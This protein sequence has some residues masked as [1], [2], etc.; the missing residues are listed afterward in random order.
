MTGLRRELGLLDATMINVGTMVGSAIFI[1]P[2]GIALALHATGPILIAW[3]VGGIVSLFGALSVAELAGAYPEAG[4]QY[5]YL[6]EAYGP[7]W[8]YLYGWAN[9]AIINAASIA[10]IAVGFAQYLGFFVP[11]GPWG[12]KLVAAATIVGLTWLNA[13]GVRLGA[14]TQNVLTFLKMA[15]LGAVVLCGLL[16]HGGSAAHLQPLWSGGSLKSLAS[17][18]GVAMVAVLWAYDG[19]IES[20]Y[21]GSEIKN[22]GRNLPW[23]IIISTLIV[24]ALY[25]LVSVAYIWVLSPAKMAGS[26]LVAAD[27]AQVVLG[28]IGAGFIALAILVSTLGAN[29]GIVL[30]AARIPY[31]MAEGG[32]FFRWAG[33]VD[34]RFATPRNALIAQG[35]LAFA[36]VFLGSYDQLAG[37]VIFASWLFYAMSCAAVIHLRGAAPDQPR[38]YRTWGYPVTPLIFIGFATW[39]VGRM[40]ADAPLE[41]AKGAGLLLLGIP[42]YL[43]WR[44]RG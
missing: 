3:I 29:N 44:R 35:G 21:V 23:S 15:A 41:S 18:F 32:L 5:A 13:R 17:P 19:W 25:T 10:A 8:G 40:V 6:R 14:T 36:L 30:T 11:L 31:A 38:P 37:Y 42:G 43:Y 39:L 28:S 22:P 1:V 27:A 2:A 34:E 7:L 33:K 24:M 16:L 4:G 20:T 26:S 9:F 12:V